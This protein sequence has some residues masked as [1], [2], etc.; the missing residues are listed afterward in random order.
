MH[1]HRNRTRKVSGGKKYVSPI[2]LEL[3]IDDPII[4]FS[5]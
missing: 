3:P 4:T 5:E 2:L 1:R